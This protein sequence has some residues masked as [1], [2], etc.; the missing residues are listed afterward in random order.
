[1]LMSEFP[2]LIPYVR[3]VS[4]IY[5][6]WIGF[7]MGKRAYLEYK[8][9]GT[10]INSR[11]LTNS[12]MLLCLI[13]AIPLVLINIKLEVGIYNEDYFSYVLWLLFGG[14]PLMQVFIMF[15]TTSGHFIIQKRK[16]LRSGKEKPL[17]K[18]E[19]SKIQRL[20]FTRKIFH[21]L[22]LFAMVGLYL[23]LAS[24]FMSQSYASTHQLWGNYAGNTIKNKFGTLNLSVSVGQMYLICAYY[25]GATMTLM[26]ETARLSYSLEFPFLL[27]I[28]RSLHKKEYNTYATHSHLA[29]G[30]L[31]ASLFMP[32]N[33]FFA[34]VSLFTI[35]DTF[36][37]L[38]G[39]KFGTHK[40]P[41]GEK[42]WEGLIAGLL[43]TFLVS[44]LFVGW[45][46]AF[47]TAL[48]YVLVDLITPRFVKVSDNLLFPIVSV[49]VYFIISSF[50]IAAQFPLATWF[51]LI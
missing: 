22:F 21:I 14:F 25:G 47:F 3:A 38:F 6:L 19:Q 51:N 39:V 27:Q 40:L 43:S 29:V 50:G 8:R 13:M 17:L 34:S 31:F 36:A 28:Q 33:F 20:H 16:V 37:A 7:L 10:I 26:I 24:F 2:N 30:Y 15:L 1:M 11:T 45:L 32:P 44:F 23:G 49:L 18:N 5:F 48:I 4:V 41:D 35:G 42:S 12:V 46:W 9:A